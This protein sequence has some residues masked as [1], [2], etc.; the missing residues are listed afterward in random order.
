MLY[1][2]HNPV[3]DNILWIAKSLIYKKLGK[4]G[5]YETCVEMV[6][7]ALKNTAEI[8]PRIYK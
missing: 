5:E 6:T 7:D 8:Q 2:A 1:S 4:Q 3:D